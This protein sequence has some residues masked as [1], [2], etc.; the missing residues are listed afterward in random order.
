MSINACDPAVEVAY[1]RTLEIETVNKYSKEP[2]LRTPRRQI[3]SG[4]PAEA[5]FLRASMT[6]HLERFADLEWS[7]LG[8]KA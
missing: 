4:N 8:Y 1:S 6:K 5:C 3:K 2:K 7:H